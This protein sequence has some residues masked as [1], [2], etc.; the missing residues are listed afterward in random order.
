MTGT[1]WDAQGEAQVALSLDRFR[2]RD[3]PVLIAET[4]TV[5]DDPI[6]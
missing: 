4:I 6:L 3:V 1:P 2:S 5:D